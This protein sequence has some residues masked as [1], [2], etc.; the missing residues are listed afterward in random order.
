MAIKAKI[1]GL[2]LAA[3]LAA[4]PAAANAATVFETFSGAPGATSSFTDVFTFTAPSDGTLSVILESFDTGPGTNVNFN[5]TYVQL[6]GVT[7]DIVSRG[8]TELRQILNLPVAAGLQTLSITGASQALGE[9]NGSFSFAS[10]PEPA[11]WGMMI[12]GLGAVGFSMRR[13]K[14]NV[15]VSYS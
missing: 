15:S 7:L 9:Y 3:A 12:L 4:A 6:N 13:R 2:A 10:V 1:S 14:A 8:V 5:A 11:T